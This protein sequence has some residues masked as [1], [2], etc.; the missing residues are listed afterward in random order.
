MLDG[1]GGGEMIAILIATE[2]SSEWMSGER[3][4]Y[5]TR[6]GTGNDRADTHQTT[7]LSDAIYLFSLSLSLS[8]SLILILPRHPRAILASRQRH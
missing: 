8:L 1:G 4:G 2:G 6:R 5:T 3:Q 7:T